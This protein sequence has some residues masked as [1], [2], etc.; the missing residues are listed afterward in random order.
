MYGED[1]V[2]LPATVPGTIHQDLQV[3][4]LIPDPYVGSNIDSVQWVEEKDWRYQCSFTPSAHLLAM[5]HSA[6]HMD[7]LTRFG[8]GRNLLRSDYS[9][10]HSP[11][12]PQHFAVPCL[13]VPCFDC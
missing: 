10:N 9:V 6:Y 4:G 11:I 7:L 5:E 13:L 8:R 12:Q 3:H 1:S 2:L